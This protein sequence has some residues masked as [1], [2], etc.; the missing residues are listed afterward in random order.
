MAKRARAETDK[1]EAAEDAAAF[2]RPTI[3]AVVPIRNPEDEPFVFR[4]E[5]GP[6]IL[7]QLLEK[8]K[9]LEAGSIQEGRKGKF[10]G[11]YQLF[12]D[13]N[14]VYIGK[15][16]RPIGTRMREHLK[17]MRGR[18]DLAR[19][20]CKFVYVEDPSLVDVA[21]GALIRVFAAHNAAE[22]NTSGFGSKAPGYGRQGTQVAAWSELFPADLN[23]PVTAGNKKS[24]TL[25]KLI[26]Q[27]NGRGPVTL[28]IPKKHRVQFDAD[29]QDS[30][31]VDEITLSF[32]AWIEVVEEFLADNWRISRDSRG[33]Y[34]EPK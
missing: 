13:G 30:Y 24:L 19:M 15:T 1:V 32:S 11:F 20:T 23:L 26:N 10:P 3:G 14:P 28:S 16:A 22:W 27:L 29:H 9:T 17:T 31:S 18:I 6:A 5:V 7:I 8:L 25:K 12:L 21:E 4:F 2:D 34:L 33:W